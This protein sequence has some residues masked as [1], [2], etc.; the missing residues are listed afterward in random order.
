MNRRTAGFTLIELLLAAVILVVV[1]GIVAGA[2][3]GTG[4]TVNQYLSKS[5]ITEDTRAAGQ[6]I[7][8][9]VASAAYV[10]PPGVKV[11][12]GSDDS[13][14]GPSGTAGTTGAWTV[15]DNFLAFIQAPKT[16]NQI[17]VVTTPDT[18]MTFVAYY[19]L[20]RSTVMTD[21]DLAYNR[22]AVSPKNDADWVLF[23]FRATL[24]FAQ[25]VTVDPAGKPT[26]ANRPPTSLSATGVT[27]G[28]F[29]ADL[30]NP[31]GGFKFDYGQA[32]AANLW[33]RY[34]QNGASEIQAVNCSD[35]NMV[36][37]TGTA[38]STDPNFTVV[39][40][41]L[42]IQALSNVAGKSTTPLLTYS[43]SPHGL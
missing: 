14:K 40:A 31:A 33:C 11:D 21:S 42:T 18:C 32:T 16:P 36:K 23:E 30:I 13:V 3:G 27:R 12:L 7:S 9:E 20:L 22:P 19:P 25:F 10:Y 2:L 35:V 38:N 26:L 34:V 39:N 1:L 17:C 6:L 37:P 5:E 8:D 29:L 43:I 41:Q 28:S 4:Q 24:P 15:G